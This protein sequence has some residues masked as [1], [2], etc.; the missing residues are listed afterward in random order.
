MRKLELTYES[1]ETFIQHFAQRLQPNTT[2]LLDGE[3]G[4][5][6][7]TLTKYLFKVLGYAGVVSSPTFNL[8]KQYEGAL[9]HLVHVDAYRNIQEGYIALGEYLEEPYILCVEWSDYI[10]SELPDEYIRITIE[11]TSSSATRVYT[12]ECCDK[13]YKEED[14]E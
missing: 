1:L 7:T 8:I 2:I 13:R 11:H 9:H 4:T 10:K 12:L 5:G 3:I 14:F 6:K